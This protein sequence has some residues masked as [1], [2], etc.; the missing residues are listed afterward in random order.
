MDVKKL[1]CEDRKW[2]ELILD[3]VQWRVLLPQCR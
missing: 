2:M 3:L 1:G